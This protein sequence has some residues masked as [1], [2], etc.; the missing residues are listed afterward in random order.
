M[1][2]P[3]YPLFPIFAF[4]GFL[5]S[6][7][8]LPW[9][10]QAMNSGTCAFMIWTAGVCF[11]EFVNSVIWSGHVNNIAPVWCDISI[12]ILLGAGIGIPASTLC[13]ARRL[14]K[15]ANLQSVSVT[16]EDKRK[17][18][19]IDLCIAVGIPIM[20]LVMHIAVHP[21]RFDI[22]EDIGCY[23]TTYNTI[24]AYFLYFM[25][26]IL[27]G[28][29]SLTYSCLNLHSFYK[30]RAQFSQLVATTSAMNTSRYLRLMVL[31]IV[32]I[33]FT[34]PLGSYL[35]YVSTNGVPL[36][37]W[38]SWEDTHFNFGRVGLV[39]ALFW[40]NNSQLSISIEFNRW[41]GP[42]CAFLFFALF[43]FA[44]EAKKNYRLAFWWIAKK[45]GFQP[46]V[47]KGFKPHI[48]KCIP[49]GT[50]DSEDMLPVY[51]ISRPH[52]SDTKKGN[53]D[54][55]FDYMS[56]RTMANVPSSPVTPSSP[57]SYTHS[58]PPTPSGSYVSL[59]DTNAPRNSMIS[60]SSECNISIY[61][62]YAPSSISPSVPVERNTSTPSHEANSSDPSLRPVT[63]PDRVYL[64]DAYYPSP[65]PQNQPPSP[66][67]FTAAAYHR[68]F[69][70]SIP[71]PTARPFGSCEPIL[72]TQ[73]VHT[74][75]ELSDNSS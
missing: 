28:C 30:R 34:L 32:D 15:I 45:L 66:P 67:P 60:A 4:L 62:V 75:N 24:P 43:G 61:S 16:R 12:Q 69:T 23:P 36:L 13:I 59:P 40:R 14:Y 57:P 20:V 64:A 58:A 39:P 73:T 72:V 74:Q 68:P 46:P 11:V 71:Y 27:L 29:V 17:A 5:C 44:S 22:L 48:P 55:E 19:I 9:H 70:L 33:M 56:N 21:H 6:L 54:T 53:S 8:P 10:I 52:S 3:T 49:S 41:L 38:I 51:V 18:I 2:D 35:V 7:I 42:F 47:A 63:P 25:W 65:A 50:K 1:A 37:P 26:P 31:S